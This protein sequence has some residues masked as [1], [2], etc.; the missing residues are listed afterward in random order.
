MKIELH[1]EEEAEK[2]K[3]LLSASYLVLAFAGTAAA[4][5]PEAVA[6]LPDGGV[7]ESDLER[8]LLSLELDAARDCTIAISA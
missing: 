7:E 3:E 6:P 5:A 1:K 8:S 2:R 4:A